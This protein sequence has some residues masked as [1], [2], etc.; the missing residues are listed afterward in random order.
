MYVGCFIY[1]P[2]AISRVT[3]LP[4]HLVHRNTGLLPD[5]VRRDSTL[6]LD[7]YSVV[8]RLL[9]RLSVCRI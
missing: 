1:S 6:S 2:Q 5:C 4:K 9:A 3:L 8:K 7:Y